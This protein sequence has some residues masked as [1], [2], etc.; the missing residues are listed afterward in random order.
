MIKKKNKYPLVRTTATVI[1]M[2]IS[3]DTPWIIWYMT[4]IQALILQLGYTLDWL[5]ATVDRGPLFPVKLYSNFHWTYLDCRSRQGVIKHRFDCTINLDL[6]ILG[7]V[8]NIKWWS[9][10]EEELTNNKI[11]WENKLLLFRNKLA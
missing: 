6:L 4:I 11:I 2:A 10:Y 5:V 7:W 1:K 8:S 9:N 3:V